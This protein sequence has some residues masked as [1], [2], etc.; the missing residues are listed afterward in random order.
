MCQF[1]LLARLT[2]LIHAFLRINDTTGLVEFRYLQSYTAPHIGVTIILHWS[3]YYASDLTTAF[4]G[5]ILMRLRLVLTVSVLIEHIAIL[6]KPQCKS[7]P[8][9]HNSPFIV[10][11]A[12]WLTALH[13]VIYQYNKG[14]VWRK[15][16]VHRPEQYHSQ[17]TKH[18]RIKIKR[19]SYRRC[20]RYDSVKINKNLINLQMCF[21]SYTL[22]ITHRKCSFLAQLCRLLEFS[23]CG[24]LM[25]VLYVALFVMSAATFFTI[26]LLISGELD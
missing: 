7:I 25:I 12:R 26:H 19:S 22:Y 2:G 3:V 24:S 11:S 23:I 16:L 10:A 21:L 18:S 20:G 6:Y 5:N 17:R 8:L 14:F 13:R 15:G 9:H 1:G 4:Y